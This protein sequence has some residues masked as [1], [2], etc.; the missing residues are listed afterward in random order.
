M[1]PRPLHSHMHTPPL[2][3]YRGLRVHGWARRLL[4]C[5]TF[6]SHLSRSLTHTPHY[7]YF[8]CRLLQERCLKEKSFFSFAV[9][10]FPIKWTAPEAA[11]PDYH[12]SI[13]SDVWSFGVLMYEIVTYGGTPYPRELSPLFLLATMLTQIVALTWHQKQ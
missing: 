11:L 3:P 8:N 2:C 1:L 7:V 9:I 5:P 4:Y 6:V 13:K 12:F 10:K